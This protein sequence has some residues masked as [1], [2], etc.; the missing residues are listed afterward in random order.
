MTG[1]QTCALPISNLI[2]ITLELKLLKDASSIIDKIPLVNYILLGKDKSISTIIKISGTIDEPIIKT[3]VVTDVLK[4]PFNI[5]KNT[6]T[7]PFVIFE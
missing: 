6:L 3:Q 4:T 5:I 1:V 7:L 2:D